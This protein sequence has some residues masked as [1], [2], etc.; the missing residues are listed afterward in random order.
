[1]VN[2][3]VL[4]HEW[5]FSLGAERCHDEGVC[6][7]QWGGQG[8]GPTHPEFARTPPTLPPPGALL[9]CQSPP[10][11]PCCGSADKSEQRWGVEGGL[12]WGEE[13]K[14]YMLGINS[15]GAWSPSGRLG[16]TLTTEHGRRKHLR[17]C[18]APTPKDRLIS[19]GPARSDK[20]QVQSQAWD[21]QPRTSG[22][23]AHQNSHQPRVGTCK[24][25]TCG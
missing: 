4:N 14:H 23:T 7:W 5:D 8:E 20:R 22:C 19:R 1:M 18:W 9:P 11:Q 12:L 21:E 15:W 24:H 2:Q 16:A 3:P 10:V 17:T 25:L 13:Q 6:K